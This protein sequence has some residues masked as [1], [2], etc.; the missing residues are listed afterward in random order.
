MFKFFSDC[1]NNYQRINKPDESTLIIPINQTKIETN[2]PLQFLTE[3][4]NTLFDNYIALMSDQVEL[5]F[6][7]EIVSIDS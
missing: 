1:L 5:S 2:A 4:E 3:D 7:I 6:T